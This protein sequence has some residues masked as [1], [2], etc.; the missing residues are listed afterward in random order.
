MSPRK[1]KQRRQGRSKERVRSNVRTRAVIN[2]PRS[3]DDLFSRPRS[4]QQ[5]WNRAVQVPAEMRANG[6]SLRQASRKLGISRNIVLRLAGSA[7][8]RKR[9]GQ[10]EVKPHDKLLRV[11]LTPSPQG[12]REIATRDS[13]EAS[14]IG[15]HWNAA[16]YFLQTG[17]DSRLRRLPRKTVRDASGKRIRLL[18]DRNELIRQGSAGEFHFESFYVAGR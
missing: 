15:Q 18:L 13:R 1:P 7:L 6:T 16:E 5:Q 2:P 4:F 17:D 11:N 8:K 14:L 12:N 9:N 3:A 10:Y